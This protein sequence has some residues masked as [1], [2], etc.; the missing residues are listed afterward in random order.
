MTEYSESV[1]KKSSMFDPDKG[2][3]E[4][5]IVQR[6][7]LLLFSLCSCLI[8]FVAFT[9]ARSFQFDA[10]GLSNLAL[11]LKVPVGVFTLSLPVFALLAASHRSEQTKQQMALTRKQIERSD[12]QIQIAGDQS[13]FSNYYKHLEEFV[14]FCAVH[15]EDSPYAIAAPRKLH[16]AIYPSARQGDI[17]ISKDFLSKFDA[18]IS[19]LYSLVRLLAS[20]ENREP[21]IERINSDH[22]Y[23]LE[24]Y[25]LKRVK[26]TTGAQ[27]EYKGRTIFVPGRFLSAFII[28]QVDLIK[29]LNEV[30]SFDPEYVASLSIQQIINFSTILSRKGEIPLV[31]SFDFDEIHKE[32]LMGI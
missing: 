13:K 25:C 10:E 8:L 17:H 21:V 6:A 28:Y 14:K 24:Q 31:G 1:Y 32:A 4:L 16:A 3:L 9:A 15:F 19:D 20:P 11:L 23:L 29:T 2:F 26:T 27:I 22:E 7:L 12:Q 5:P 18:N 30:L